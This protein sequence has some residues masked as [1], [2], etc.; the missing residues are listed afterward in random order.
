MS[1]RTAIDRA[2]EPSC[3][4]NHTAR[5]RCNGMPIRGHAAPPLRAPRTDGYVWMCNWL[6]VVHL[7]WTAF[8]SALLWADIAWCGTDGRCPDRLGLF[9]FLV[10][11]QLILVVPATA[12]CALLISY[13]LRGNLRAPFIGTAAYMLQG[14]LWLIIL[15]SSDFR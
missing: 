7:L 11:E 3:D 1:P 10:T 14:A 12:A 4:L 15:S 6:L 9:A 2:H 13:I 8:W 5:Q